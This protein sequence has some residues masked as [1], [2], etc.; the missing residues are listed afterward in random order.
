MIRINV[1]AGKPYFSGTKSLD[2]NTYRFTF[3][4]NTASEKWYM[5]IQ[6]ISNTVD[7]RGIACLPG[8]DLLK[9]HGYSQLGQ[10]WIVDNVGRNE[11]P[12]F[13]SF[14]GRHTVEYTPV[15]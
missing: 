1:P 8:K 13:E 12:T 15:Q 3:R 6:G 7:I 11:N 5:D 2:G 4:W 14:G 9:I 10:L